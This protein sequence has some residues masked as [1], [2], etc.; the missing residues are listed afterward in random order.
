MVWYAERIDEDDSSM[1]RAV[2]T[3]KTTQM[4]HD[5]WPME[6]VSRQE[7]LD[8]LA[9]AL[10]A[11]EA[12]AELNAATQAANIA[13]AQRYTL[14]DMIRI[15][16]LL[17]RKGGPA[18]ETAETFVVSLLNRLREEAATRAVRS[19]QELVE[20]FDSVNAGV[21][22][23]DAR[24][25]I[26]ADINAKGLHILGMDKAEVV[27]RSCESL[28]AEDAG[29]AIPAL[30]VG[31]ST[32][33][34]SALVE[35][36]SGKKV[37]VLLAFK[38]IEFQGRTSLLATFVDITPLKEAQRRA[39]EARVE[40][41]IANRAK[42]EFLANMS[43]EIRTP[44]NGVIGMTGLLLE[45][46]LSDEQREYAET[47]RNSGQALLD[48]INDILDFSKIEAGKLSLEAEDFDLRDLLENL[49]DL[50]GLQAQQKGLEYVCCIDP[51]VPPRLV[52]DAGRLR[53]I[54]TNVIG[55]AIKFTASGEVSIDVTLTEASGESATLE[56]AV[57]DTGPGI[58]EDRRSSIFEEFAQLDS[59][60]A[61]KHG[62]TGL[63]L[64]IARRLVEMMGGTIS[65]ESPVPGEHDIASES[66]GPGALFRFTVVC[67]I[68]TNQT[69]TDKDLAPLKANLRERRF[70]IVDDNSTN[71]RLLS[72]L[73]G[74]WNCRHDEAACAQEAMRK[75]KQGLATNDPF[76]VA[77]LDMQMPMTDGETLGRW[78]K[79][80]PELRDTVLL[81]MASSMG[82]HRDSESLRNMGFAASLAKP[83]KQSRLH[84]CLVSVVTEAD[85]PPPSSA[86]PAT[87]ATVRINGPG[88]ARILVAEDNRINQQVAVGILCKL[89]YHAE[90]VADGEET[91]EALE[92]VPYDLVLMDCQMPEMDGYEATRLIRK[93]ERQTGT[94]RIPIVAMT[95]HALKGDREECLAA[96]MDDYV[97]KPIN[98]ASLEEALNRWLADD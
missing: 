82:L 18:G 21:F 67:G 22:V 9:E 11:E 71:R 37:P 53:Q 94:P 24:T 72:V 50:L 62:G 31:E 79:E 73:L 49:N 81:V 13:E 97:S 86:P 57:A 20:V 16:I 61:R 66:H 77:I 95:A 84:D 28:F 19:K 2:P 69:S 96:G 93:K 40:A 56:F 92:T 12:E 98:P 85:R 39:V 1:R 76:N 10:P 52:G 26:V 59:G 5:N 7:I 38:G 36:T 17:A 4:T 35:N 47:V 25:R 80:D 88:K 27:G 45:T 75:L 68:G 55:N 3:C 64:T 90:A 32:D 78:I 42:S 54:L 48:L 30:A 29:N 43:H 83:I 60:T 46:N 8:A 41:E 74:S 70:L 65:V 51:A 33:N 15:A 34:L 23:A 89:G 58:P 87:P 14:A 44:M 91:I 63:G 6:S